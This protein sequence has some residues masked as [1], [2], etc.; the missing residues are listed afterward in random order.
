MDSAPTEGLDPAVKLDH[1]LR[2][3]L[4]AVVAAI[5]QLEGLT[6]QVGTC[7]LPADT[8]AQAPDVMHAAI[9][10]LGVPLV[11]N[12]SVGGPGHDFAST[13]LA[14]ELRRAQRNLRLAGLA[15]D[16]VAALAAE[17]VTMRDQENARY[18]VH[19]VRRPDASLIRI[20]EAGPPEAPVVLVS[21][22]CAM[23]YRLSFRWLWALS[24]THRVLIPQTRGTN[25]RI[26][27]PEV[28]D[29]RGYDVYDQAE[30]LMGIIEVLTDSSVH[31]MGMCGGAVPGLIVAAE[32]PAYVHSLS[33]WHADLELGDEAAKTDHQANLRALLDVA[34]ESREA[35]GAV[36]DMLTCSP[37]TGIPDGIGPL[38][39]RPYATA[40]LFYRYAKL[41]A[42]TMHW[43][44]RETARAVSQP[45]AII[46]SRDDNT[47][48]P[49]GSRRLA[50][51]MPNASLTMTEHGTHLTAFAA[52]SEQVS[53]LASFLD[54][55]PGE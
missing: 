13:A 47:A 44:S 12:G 24:D 33:L 42:A 7:V 37:L 8:C 53:W 4:E 6:E 2:A 55:F 1:D 31:I 15:P 16:L 34:G 14:A 51:I 9:S 19:T 17:A 45:S 39:V 28:F 3:A 26:E 54:S 35:A 30:D 43:D 23:S 49:D 36:R 27:D 22:P 10:A 29:R 21:P 20:V 18:Q 48:H 40:E 25:G 11:F 32:Q 38:V 46:T 50:E 5:R 41:T 52:T